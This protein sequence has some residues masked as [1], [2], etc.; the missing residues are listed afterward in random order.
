MPYNIDMDV[1]FGIVGLLVIVFIAIGIHCYT[2]WKI[3]RKYK[4]NKH[5]VPDD[6]E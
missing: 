4:S 2:M 6:F 5:I 3:E 1:L